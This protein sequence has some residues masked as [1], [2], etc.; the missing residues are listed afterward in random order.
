MV[1]HPTK[2]H[3]MK[4]KI[5]RKGSGRKKNQLFALYKG[6]AELPAGKFQTLA[7]TGN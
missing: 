6:K 4:K 3:D 5:T 1:F 2:G 7:R